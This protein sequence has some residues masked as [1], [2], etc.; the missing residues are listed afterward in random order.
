MIMEIISILLGVILL[1]TATYG[2]GDSMFEMYRL[3]FLI[4]L[5]SLIIVLVFT[6]P[7]LFKGGVWKDFM[8]AWKL[9]RKDY[10][11][12]LSELRRTLD[13]VEMMQKQLIYA[14]VLCMLLSFITILG[15]LTRPE[16]LGPNLAVAILT[17]LY[18][19][20]F[21]MLLLPLQLEVKRRIIDYME[22][23]TD[24]ERESVVAGRECENVA[25]EK[26]YENVTAVKEKEKSVIVI[27]VESGKDVTVKEGEAAK[28]RMKEMADR[29]E[30]G[31]A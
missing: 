14:G 24:A 7:A 2:N 6:V 9:L 4:D 11:C 5:P 8:R 22:L 13:V 20:I 23:D 1:G 29:T 18:A 10:T 19:V 17:I 15:Q 12:H 28:K 26:E 27:E 16:H 21:E 31:Q 30:E 3:R 25:V